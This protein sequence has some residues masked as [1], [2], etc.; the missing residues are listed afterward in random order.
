MRCWPAG[1]LWRRM[2]HR[3]DEL[4]QFVRQALRLGEAD[5][6]TSMPLAKR[7]SSRSFYRIT[8]DLDSSVVLMCYDHVREENNHYAAIADFLLK[9]HVPVPRI[10]AHDPARGFIVMEDLGDRDLWSCRDEPWIRR[11]TYYR[12]TL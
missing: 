4:L 2:K 10:L 1:I 6:L 7:G 5:V 8:H 3:D 9:I 11:S 12:G